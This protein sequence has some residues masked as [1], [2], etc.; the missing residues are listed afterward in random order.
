MRPL[1]ISNER[2]FIPIAWRL[3]REGVKCDIYV[4][5]REMRACYEG[6]MPRLS[7]SELQLRLT[8]YDVVFFDSTYI[9]KP[10]LR[11]E[12]EAVI[13]AFG[14]PKDSLEM[15]GAWADRLRHTHTVIGASAMTG[16]WEMDR[17][18]GMEI[19]RK[20]GFSIPEYEDFHTIKDGVKFLQKQGDGAL[21]VLKPHA[22]DD[23][24]LTYVEHFPGD[25]ARHM[26][27][28]KFQKRIKGNN[29]SFMLQ[30]KIEGGIEISTEG[31]FDGTE[32]VRWDR[33]IENKCLMVGDLGKR[34]GCASSIVWEAQKEGLAIG[35]IRKLTPW[36]RKAGFIGGIDANC[37][38]AKRDGQPITYFLEWTPRCG[39]DALIALLKLVPEG[40]IHKFLFK[41]FT[42]KF[43]PGFAAAERVTI[44][45]Y[46]YFEKKL[47]EEEAAD[48]PI[49]HQP[50]ELPDFWLQDVYRKD[51]YLYCAGKD[52]MLGVVTGRGDTIDD[53]VAE[54]F[55]VIKGLQVGANLQYRLDLGKRAKEA[56]RK[57]ESWGVQIF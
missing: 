3:R 49:N 13:K 46:P 47:L 28:E 52:G 50:E 29:F 35:A 27:S 51:G 38:V 7:L 23:C 30:Q 4:H 43:L 33:T 26:Q 10:P 54:V 1:I 45:P 55:G 9:L 2:D 5:S 31:W 15:F 25:L 41:G 21:W 18:L 44:P 34:T 12:D 42:E 17:I 53:A 22:S 32:F 24:D 16:K 36:L 20:I 48:V 6:I 57:L 8:L 11:P 56:I 40:C 37:I 39:W 19:A 14:L